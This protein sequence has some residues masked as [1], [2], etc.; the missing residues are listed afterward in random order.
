MRQAIGNL[1][2]DTDAALKL[3]CNSEGDVLYRT[4]GACIFAVASA[5]FLNP[6]ITILKPDEAL[7]AFNRCGEKYVDFKEAFPDTEWAET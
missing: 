5:P 7:L 6:E 1:V 2:F 4:Q 3:A